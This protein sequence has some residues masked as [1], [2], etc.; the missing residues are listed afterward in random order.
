M[1]TLLLQE[2]QVVV[3]RYVLAIATTTLTGSESG[4]TPEDAAKEKDCLNEIK[5]MLNAALG[6]AANCCGALYAAA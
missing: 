4:L 1:R 2:D 5:V 3:L 6:D